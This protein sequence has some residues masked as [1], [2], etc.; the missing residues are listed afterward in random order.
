MLAAT[1]GERPVVVPA[2]GYGFRGTGVSF[3]IA[4]AL[5][6]GLAGAVDA[7]ALTWTA[8]DLIAEGLVHE[9]QHARPGGWGS[10]GG[11]DVVGHG[12]IVRPVA[13]RRLATR[14]NTG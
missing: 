8:A 6:S 10:G 12:R 3:S 11:Y 14:A 5:P 9:T 4:H 13:P 1:T 2:R 7:S